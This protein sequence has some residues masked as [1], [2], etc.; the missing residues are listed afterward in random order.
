MMIFIMV[1]LILGDEGISYY[2]IWTCGCGRQQFLR[3]Y[4]LSQ[5][6]SSNHESA[7]HSRPATAKHHNRETIHKKQVAD[8][9][10]IHNINLH[11]IKQKRH[12]SH[13]LHLTNITVQME[14]LVLI[15]SLSSPNSSFCPDNTVTAADEEIQDLSFRF[16]LSWPWWKDPE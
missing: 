9:H 3:C 10:L 15:T 2:H 7:L 8:E 5:P 1:W 11:Q 6:S 14:V 4:S 13:Y 12:N 16:V